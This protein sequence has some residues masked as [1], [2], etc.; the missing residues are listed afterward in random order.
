[1]TT[2]KQKIEKFEGQFVAVQNT[3]QAL[4]YCVESLDIV[5]HLT[6]DFPFWT[7][8]S[9]YAKSTPNFNATK[10]RLSVTVFSSTGKHITNNFLVE[11]RFF[12]TLKSVTLLNTETK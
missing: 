9:V 3:S 11:K 8:K 2:R 7:V 5:E 10:T 1:M 12:Q 4:A 6:D